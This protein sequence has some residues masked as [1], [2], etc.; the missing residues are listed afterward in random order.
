MW[1][2]DWLK[3]SFNALLH[4][5]DKKLKK[6]SLTKSKTNYGD[7]W[8]E[9]QEITNKPLHFWNT[10]GSCKYGR[11]LQ[12]FQLLETIRHIGDVTE[13]VLFDIIFSPGN[14]DI[15]YNG[16][17]DNYIKNRRKY[18]TGWAQQLNFDHTIKWEH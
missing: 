3:K 16:T 13:N 18:L 15:L 1:E 10:A 17:R 5:P 14:F 8:L 12:I 7:F 2:I 4:C 11:K 6:M 9:G